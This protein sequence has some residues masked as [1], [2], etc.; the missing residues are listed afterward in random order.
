MGQC[1]MEQQSGNRGCQWSRCAAEV[2][3]GDPTIAAVV[4]VGRWPSAA[5]WQSACSKVIGMIETREVSRSCVGDHPS[6]S[7]I[8]VQSHGYAEI[9]EERAVTSGT[10]QA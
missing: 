6:R 9:L 4:E 2:P 8:R 7:R 10:S 3:L 1:G 5:A